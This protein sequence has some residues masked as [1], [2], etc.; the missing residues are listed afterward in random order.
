MK[1]KI[2]IKETIKLLGTRGVKYL[3]FAVV[4]S[5]VIAIIEL[6]MSIIIQLLLISFGL[7]SEEVKFLTFST[8][9]ISLLNISIILIVIA[10]I[11][12]IVQLTTTQ[13][14]SFLKEYIFL[15]LR[16]F[17]IYR[18]LY[19]SS[20]EVKNSSA[21]NFKISELYSKS[22][23]FIAFFTNALCM[24]V[25]TSILLCILYLVAWKEAFIATIGVALIG[26][27]VFKI[28]HLV[29]K[30]AKQVPTQQIKLNEGIE[31]I[32][33]NFLF[34]KL[35]KKRD[36]EYN[37]IAEALKEYSA[38]STS[39]YF[40]SNLATQTGPFLGILLLVCIISISIGLFHTNG[41]TLISFIYLL[42]R[43]V[44]SLSIFSGYYGN[45]NTFFPQYKLS[46]MSINSNFNLATKESFDRIR[47]NGY[48]KSFKKNIT[49]HSLANE[50][51]EF[52]PS[53]TITFTNVTFAYPNSLPIFENLTMT[54]EKGSQIG[55]IGASGTGKSTLL[56][57]LTGL[58]QPNSGQ[59]SIDNM[60]P[61]EYVSQKNIRIGYVGAEPYLIKGTIKDNLCYGV[62]KEINDLEILNI[63]DKVSLS[64]IIK[65][66]GL[67][68]VIAEDQSG[69]SAGQKQRICLAR[70]LLNEPALL[71]LDEAT[72]NLDEEN[73]YLI[74]KILAEI[75]SKCTTVIVSHRAGI[76]KFADKIIDLTSLKSV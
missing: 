25:Q 44:Q 41:A 65:E 43:F 5:I 20:E 36:E 50:K 26:L 15:K 61:W 23:E 72:A 53:P 63:L 29:A 13:T 34:I 28:N 59:A 12:F 8:P 46:L 73:E 64:S 9:K 49:N 57:L 52:Q 22:S 38:K 11:R 74:A 68:Y 51:S 66:K 42:S 18:I 19:E 4:S 27:I 48:R 76:L 7:L 24:L 37:E 58:L 69:L 56:F 21:I 14:A 40:Y 39:A 33:R 45:A 2:L 6:S 35:M 47:L 31:K 54:F 30:N 17:S 67:S 62:S 16:R 71:I 75:K 1:K 55:L 70:A 60:P 3:I 32:S 10:I